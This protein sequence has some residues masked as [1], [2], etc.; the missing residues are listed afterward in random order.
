[1]DAEIDAQRNIRHQ[2][3]QQMIKYPPPLLGCSPLPVLTPWSRYSSYHHSCVRFT[4]FTGTKVQT[5]LRPNS[6][7]L[8]LG[9][10]FCKCHSWDLQESVCGCVD[11][12]ISKICSA[13]KRDRATKDLNE[14]KETNRSSIL[15]RGETCTLY[16]S[17]QEERRMSQ[18][19][20]FV[21]AWNW[22]T[23]NQNK[24][25]HQTSD[26]GLCFLIFF[27]PH[28]SRTRRNEYSS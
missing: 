26:L 21:C 15:L 3:N 22:L 14:N 18:N 19:L 16:F 12:A 11:L 20:T 10:D 23:S 13:G 24:E 17:V 7:H 8:K 4:C 1:M 25:D 9:K 27:L 28:L 5:Q 2:I 6:M